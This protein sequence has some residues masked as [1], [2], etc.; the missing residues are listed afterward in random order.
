MLISTF[1]PYTPLFHLA[2]RIVYSIC[3]R[4]F[5]D[6]TTIEAP[7][8]DAFREAMLAKRSPNILYTAQN[9]DPKIL[10]LLARS[11]TSSIIFCE[12][13]LNAVAGI[14]H[15]HRVDV[16]TGIRM[17]FSHYVAMDPLLDS[18][19]TAFI[20]L[21]EGD[22]RLGAV[23]EQVLRL[24]DYD[25]DDAFVQTL[26]GFPPSDFDKSVFELAWAGRESAPQRDAQL[27]FSVRDAEM[28]DM[29]F[30]SIQ[31]LSGDGWR[32]PGRLFY[33]DSTEA[34]AEGPIS[35]LGKSRTLFFGPYL[36]LPIGRWRA[37]YH[38]NVAQNHSG[39]IVLADVQ[40]NLKVLA[41]GKLK[42][43]K[44]GSFEFSLDFDVDSP[45]QVVEIRLHMLE[46]AIGG[47][48]EL[49]HVRLSRI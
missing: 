10:A 38:L 39:N 32:W 30:P 23:I 22:I 6:L 16:A 46:G 18:D 8:F 24:L 26:S 7:Q 2:L 41:V 14:K 28:I 48:I 29:M 1:G 47:Y 31:N 33:A 43:P 3:Q 4:R 5:E 49:I 35:L 20:D 21:G 11:G 19:R 37:T 15:A 40:A 42:L 13:P 17:L 34:N 36:S 12:R 27:E 9:P 25:V 45:E 44:E